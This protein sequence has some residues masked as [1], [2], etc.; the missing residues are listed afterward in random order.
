M[1]I[2][3]WLISIAL[4][5]PA[6]LGGDEG[7]AAHLGDLTAAAES[8]GDDPEIALRLA[9]ALGVRGRTDD[10]LAWLKTATRRGAHPLRVELVAGDIHLAAERY[11]FALTAYFEV[12]SQAPHNRYAHLRMWRVL[13][14]A[15]IL[16]PNVDV[17]RL[18]AHLRDAGYF[19]PDRRV[20]PPKTAQ[21]RQLTDRAMVTLKGGG[22]R[23]ALDGFAAALSLDDGYAPAFRGMGIA[24][25]R[26]GRDDQALGAYRL[27]LFLTETETRETRQVR[28]ILYDADRR[29]GL[30][31]ERRPSRRR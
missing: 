18:R 16:P 30:A 19:V 15:D 13:R 27:Y 24:Y 17:A 2:L 29:R 9:H 3:G 5:S 25:A 4:A 7:H 1:T 21:A 31:A 12:A 6:A 14:E 11:E 28:R 10:A 23:E 26:L 20:R 22:F 8:H